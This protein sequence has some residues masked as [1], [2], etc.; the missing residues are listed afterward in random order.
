MAGEAV[1][2]GATGSGA[3]LGWLGGPW[4][5]ALSILAPTL[6]GSIFGQGGVDA[7]TLRKN[8][9]A[10]LTGTAIENERAVQ[11]ANLLNS[12]GLAAAQA[13]AIQGG[14]AGAQAINA[15]LGQTGLGRSGVGMALEGAVRAAPDVQMA[16]MKG[17]LANEAL[18]KAI[19]I[20]QQ[21][22]NAELAGGPQ[23]SLARDMMAATVAGV[24]PS[25]LNAQLSQKPNPT[26][27]RTPSQTSMTRPNPAGPFA[28]VAQPLGIQQAFQDEM[29]KRREN[30]FGRGPVLLGGKQVY[31]PQTNQ[32]PIFPKWQ[33]PKTW[34]PPAYKVPPVYANQRE[35]F[36]AHP[37]NPVS[38]WDRMGAGAIN[39]HGFGNFGNDFMPHTFGGLGNFDTPLFGIYR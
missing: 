17:Q 5:M 27:K 12:P 16:M 31:L 7:K 11:L 18:N 34:Q 15:R 38:I 23:N 4:G 25:L 9:L 37:R 3:N 28:P 1:V 39:R 20:Q 2:A 30:I 13:Q 29:F 24:M 22:A 6:L 32:Q 36:L 33:M 10:R 26:N 19:E 8:A 14:Q 35:Y 21:R